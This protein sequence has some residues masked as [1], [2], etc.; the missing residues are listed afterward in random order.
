MTCHR[1]ANRPCHRLLELTDLGLSLQHMARGLRDRA[2]T[3]MV[4][5]RANRDDDDAR[6]S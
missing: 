6:T 4:E 2:Q 1:D 3:H 5:V